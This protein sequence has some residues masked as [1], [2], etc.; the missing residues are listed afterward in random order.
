MFAAMKMEI[1]TRIAAV[2]RT[3]KAESKRSV[4][5]LT[6]KTSRLETS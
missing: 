1:Y 3:R 4:K 5:E 6:Q 2:K